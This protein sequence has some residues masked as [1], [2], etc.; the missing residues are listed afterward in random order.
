M[1]VTGDY[2]NSLIK[3]LK[4]AYKAYIEIYSVPF[5]FT[6][7]DFTKPTELYDRLL[8]ATS[9]DKV[10][11]VGAVQNLEIIN[12]RQLNIWRE[13]DYKTA[14]RPVESYPGLP[15]YDLRLDRIVLYDSML[16]D[17]FYNDVDDGLDISK[18]TRPLLIKVNLICPDDTGDM[19]SD[20]LLTKTWF[21]YGVWF[22]ESNI[23]FGVDNVDDIKIIQSTSAR[24]AGIVGSR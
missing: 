19:S 2:K 24:A 14:G 22:L 9:S 5:D 6:G 16:S 21:I 11:Q 17:E 4:T 23:E 20:Q 18:Q 12:E 3:G 15:G 8:K 10:R 13:L 7:A 1:A